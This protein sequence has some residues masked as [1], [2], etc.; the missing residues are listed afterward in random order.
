MKEVI[1]EGVIGS[2]KDVF[3]GSDKEIKLINGMDNLTIHIIEKKFVRGTS[4][5]VVKGLENISNYFQKRLA[6]V[7]RAA[8]VQCLMKVEFF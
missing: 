5:G 1:E 3:K 8:K 4:V 7:S 6:S 2:R